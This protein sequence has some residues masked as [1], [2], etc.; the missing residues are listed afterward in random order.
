[1][2]HKPLRFYN[3]PE[4]FT[5]LSRNCFSFIMRDT[6]RILG[7]TGRHRISAVKDRES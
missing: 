6:T 1:M 5:E 4:L 7:P 3:F 2:F